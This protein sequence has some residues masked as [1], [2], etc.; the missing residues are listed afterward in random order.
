MP[1][2]HPIFPPCSSP[3]NRG[4]MV[5]LLAAAMTM[6]ARAGTPTITSIGSLTPSA[7]SYALGINADGSAV[8]GYCSPT[9]GIRAVRWTASGGLQNLGVV[10]G[11]LR[12]L[13]FAISGDGATVTGMSVISG[14]GRVF[15]WTAGSGMFD[16][17]SLPGQNVSYGFAISAD[18]QII[19]GGTSS[20][21]DGHAL[22]WTDGIMEDLG[23][24]PGD[25]GAALYGLS[26]DGLAGAGYSRTG[27]TEQ[28]VYWTR[29]GGMIGLGFL[30]GGTESEAEAISG[31]GRVVTGYSDGTAGTHA[32]RWTAAGGMQDLST[33]AGRVT[34]YGLAINADGSAIAGNDEVGAFLWTADGGMMDLRTYLLANGV[35]LSNWTLSHCRGISADGTALAGEGRFNGQS[36]G[37]VVRGL[38]SL[39]APHITSEPADSSSCRFMPTRFSVGVAGAGVRSYEW[40]IE[41][42]PGA[43]I[44]LGEDPLPMACGGSARATGAASAEADIAIRPCPLQS[45]FRVRCVITNSC[46]ST[47][48]SPALLTVCTADYN[49]DG[50]VDGADV[51]AFF[52]DWESG[53]DSADVNSDGGV[54]GADVEAFYVPWEAG[55]C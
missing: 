48:S 42:A 46:G 52:I 33:V 38:P 14:G 25:A 19:A 20:G 50:G 29:D 55:G 15:Q 39:C 16:L 4:A 23:T 41:E 3:P 43:W 17:G 36:R 9:S 21:G 2:F 32:F 49:C 37:W 12:S 13:G 1:R 30:P 45:A 6:T 18:G 11:G 44:A 34:S 27:T 31:D 35:D 28:A 10:P 8:V 7:P 47:T 54:D 22:R 51:E 24:L 40:Q 26:A 5:L 53:I